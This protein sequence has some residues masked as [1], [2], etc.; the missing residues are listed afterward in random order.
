VSR[1]TVAPN[2]HRYRNSDCEAAREDLQGLRRGRT[3]PCP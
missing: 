1:A 3:T 2:A